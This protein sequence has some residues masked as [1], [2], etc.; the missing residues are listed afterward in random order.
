MPPD[1]AIA[2]DGRI[3]SRA[4]LLCRNLSVAAPLNRIV[5]PLPIPVSIPAWSWIKRQGP[6]VE[7]AAEDK[8]LLLSNVSLEVPP[9]D[10]MAI[11]G[12]SGSGKY[13]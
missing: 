7:A 3:A 11:I 9:G 5:L 1:A 12:G 8:R 4:T 2:A 13:A 6:D 10:L